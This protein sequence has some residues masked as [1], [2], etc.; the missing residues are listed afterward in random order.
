MPV[1]SQNNNSGL[2]DLSIVPK[3]IKGWSWGGFLLTWV[4]G[5]GNNVWIGLLALIPIPP[6][7]LIIAFILG[8]NGRE[9][10]WRKKHWKSVESF[11]STQKKWAVWGLIFMVLSILLC[12]TL[13]VCAIL[14]YIIYG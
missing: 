10:A 1:N 6:I 8:L 2:G 14:P 3:E 4:W 9:W 13:F 5:I 7:T 12:V 11:K